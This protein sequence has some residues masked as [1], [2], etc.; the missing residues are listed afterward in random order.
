MCSY[1]REERLRSSLALIKSLGQTNR[2]SEAV[3]YFYECHNAENGL[4]DVSV[5]NKIIHICVASKRLDDGRRILEQ[6]RQDS[7]SEINGVDFISGSCVR[8]DVVTYNII[9]KVSNHTNMSAECT[10]ICTHICMQGLAKE[11]PPRLSEIRELID[12]ME[13]PFHLGGDGLRAD[14]VTFST[15]IH[16][17]ATARCTEETLAFFKMMRSRR[18]KVDAFTCATLIKS[19]E[20]IKSDEI[21]EELCSMVDEVMP[22]AY[23]PQ[24]PIHVFLLTYISFFS[25]I[26]LRIA[27]T[28]THTANER[29]YVHT[30][31]MRGYTHIALYAWA[32]HTLH[33]AAS[34]RVCHYWC[35]QC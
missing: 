14:Q 26:W 17:A 15:A 22:A 1:K 30:H 31:Y 2:V 4:L 9:V 33:C 20:H 3:R 23:S 35:A 29:R 6:L 19:L 11:K 28:R 8:P 25:W 32:V 7:H 10:D 13:K 16:A 5:A 12:R 27:A 21:A 34:P 18:V 24:P